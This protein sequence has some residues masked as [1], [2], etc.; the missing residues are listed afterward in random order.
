MP[1]LLEVNHLT[2]RYG[3]RAAVDDLSFVVG[4]GEAYGLLGPNGAGKTTT[5]KILAGLVAPTSGRV[6]VAG[7]DPMV[8]PLKAKAQL[9]WVSQDL[10]LYD[11]LTAEENLRLAATLGRVPRIEVRRRCAELLELTGLADR[12]RDRAGTYSG[13]MKRRL[14][15]AMALA[16]RPR[17]LLLD[18]PLAGVDPQARAHLVDSIRALAEGG[19]ALLLTTHDMDDAERLCHRVGIMDHGSL[20]AEGTVDELRARLGE[21][22]LLRLEGHFDPTA[23]PPM[24][25][26]VEGERLSVSADSL[27]VAVSHGGTALP[28]VLAAAEA[29]GAQ[30]ER[31]TLERPS[32]ETVF[33][34]LTGRELR[35]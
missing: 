32:L 5:I 21:R 11:D 14:H 35:D 10:A 12:A 24:P 6:R 22:D 33:L 18:E 20:L 7:H 9:G 26:E 30:V 34:A 29:A 31:V 4:P 27:L 3:E 25:P 15:L 16:H 1:H 17:V 13:G 2:K 28:R 19:C 8:E 23:P